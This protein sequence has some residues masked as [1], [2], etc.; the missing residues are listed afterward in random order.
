MNFLCLLVSFSV[1]SWIGS[2][3]FRYTLPHSS[4]HSCR[5]GAL[6]TIHNNTTTAHRTN[7]RILSRYGINCSLYTYL[8][9]LCSVFRVVFLI[10]RLT[11]L[12][13]LL[14]SIV[15]HVPL[16]YPTVVRRAFSGLGLRFGLPTQCSNI[17]RVVLLS[18]DLASTCPCL[19]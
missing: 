14:L 18:P 3:W 11:P 19:L 5:V 6:N 4:I 1:C 8:A 15:L 7:H 10:A 9:L 13:P 12:T 17:Y 16:L 2:D